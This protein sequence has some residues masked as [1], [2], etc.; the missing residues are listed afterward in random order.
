MGTIKRTGPIALSNT[1]TTN[2]YQGGGGSALLFDVIRHI[3]ICNKLAADTFRLYLGA[4]ATNAVGTE[5]FFDFPVGAKLTYDYGC[6]MKLSSTDF[7][8]GGAATLL[9]LTIEIEYEQFIV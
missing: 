5:L 7:L 1:Y 2:I 8:V 6:A 9:T 3:H 4:S